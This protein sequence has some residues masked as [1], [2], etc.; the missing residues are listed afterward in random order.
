[1][2]RFHLRS[3]T[4]ALIPAL[5]SGLGLVACGSDSS[6]TGDPT[7]GNQCTPST[8]VCDG[9]DNDCD[10]AIDLGKDSKALNEKCDA[11]NGK[12][13]TRTCVGGKWGNCMSDCTPKT[14]ECNGADDDCDGAVDRDSQGNP[15]TK[16]CD[17]SGKV[18]KQT[19]TAGSWGNCVA[20]CTPKAEECNGVDDDCD[21]K[22]DVDGNG[23]P[24]TKI[25]DAAGKTGTQTC[26]SGAWGNCVCNNA[27]VEVCN[28]K[29]DDCDGKTDEDD[30]GK[31]LKRSCDTAC[32]PGTE[33]CVNGA[34]EQCNAP[35]PSVEKCDG[36][37]NDCNGKVDD[38]FD[39]AKGSTDKC[40]TDTGLCEYGT[41]LCDATCKWGACLGGV[42][43]VTEACD[44]TNDEDCDGTV[45]NGCGCTNGVQKDCCG[46]TKIT[47][48][49]GTWPA[50]P[51]TPKEI[52]NSIDDDCNGLVDD[53]LPTDPFLLEEDV[54]S[55]DD[56]A[57]AKLVPTT[58]IENDPAVDG[59]Y[60]IYKKDL[61]IDRD[62]FSF[63]TQEVDDLLCLFNPSHN[64]CYTLTITLNE[65]AG[66][67]Y[68]MCLYDVDLPGSGYT[69]AQPATTKVCSSSSKPNKIVYNIAGGCGTDEGFSYFLEVFAAG[70]TKDSCKPY[71][72]SIE[73]T[74]SGPQQAT[75]TFP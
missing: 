7:P 54:T 55:V 61:V 63:N 29:D 25:C 71:S 16:V 62:F 22:A 23:K 68:E 3:A 37:D 43:P 32:G 46:G 50:C 27:E 35:Q 47:C 56:C 14:E 73:L 19:C 18:G 12:V 36:V 1:M 72:I 57:H 40:G 58:V 39:C 4:V 17:A 49:G 69:C 33:V 8:E 28:G 15:L 9:L 11:G 65:P 66:Q 44:G 67:D 34:F 51:A 60:Y 38:G 26:T 45:D 5:L 70:N 59:T 74:G 53:G 20:D 13:G 21:G 64:E 52:C 31:A 48:T 2:A 6:T 24:I 30:T 42:I 41:K 10:G 75:C